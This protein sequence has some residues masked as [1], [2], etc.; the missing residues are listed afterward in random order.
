MKVKIGYNENEE[1]EYNSNIE[2]KKLAFNSCFEYCSKFLVIENKIEFAKDFKGY[3]LKAWE[4]KYS[5]SFPPIVSILKQLELSDCQGSIIEAYQTQYLNIAIDFDAETQKAKDIDFNIYAETPEQIERFKACQSL[6]EA[7][8]NLQSTGANI[9]YGSLCQ[10][11]QSVLTI[12]YSTNKLTP[13]N[14]FIFN[15]YR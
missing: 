12:D 11:M 14:Q 1:L 6:I 5:N 2:N 3:F 7:I 8:E 10:S 15:V 4:Q 13:T 9:M